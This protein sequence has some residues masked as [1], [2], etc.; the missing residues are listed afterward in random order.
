MK[1]TV[2]TLLLITLI[3]TSS[4]RLHA[5]QYYA[6]C[7]GNFGQANAS[8]WSFNEALSTTE[9]PLIWNT[10]TN[11]LGDV[12]QSLTLYNHT[13]YIVMN[14]SHVI[15]MLNLQSGP[16]FIGDIDL[17]DASPRC[18]AVQPSQTRAFVSSWNLGGLLVIDL[19]SNTVTDTLLLG[20]LPEELLIAGDRL[21]VTMNMQLDW[22]AGN[23]VLE[24]DIAGTA[25]A[26]TAS[27][28]VIAGPGAMVLQD[29]QLYVTSV[30][31]NDSWEAFTGT[32]RI[33]LDDGNVL[34]VDHGS[35]TNYTADIDIIAGRPYRV[36][37][38]FIAGL[39]DDLTIDP[40]SAIGN[41]TD[42]Y[43]FSV[44]GDRV[45]L[46]T[47]D[48]VAPDNILVY[49]LTGQSLGNITLGAL[50]GDVIYY[51]PDIV[52]LAETAVLPASLLLQPNFPNPFNPETHIRFQVHHSAQLKLTIYDITG[53]AIRTILDGNLAAGY[54]TL[55]WDGHD[56]QGHAM[57]SG[58]YWAVLASPTE[59]SIIRMTLLR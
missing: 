43:S 14:S 44:R 11:P 39:N 15:R 12:G 21:F 45:I 4:P 52:N 22:S 5:G 33:D 51:D 57:T 19:N 7:E 10:D 40:T 36:Y 56:Q 30:Y 26:I 17:P 27:Y 54:H 48:F 20:G 59:R 46:G 3:V 13:L 25:P 38:N 35:F 47:S 2:K 50:P 34:A 8:L 32:S 1:L 53:R 37:G 29:N 55:T 18:M 28:P 9:G 16:E 58:I 24:L 23:E 49:S 41:L 31:Y 6:L 42:I